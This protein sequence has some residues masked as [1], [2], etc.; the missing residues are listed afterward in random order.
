MPSPYP[1]VASRLR[2]D[3]LL[4]IF[5]LALLSLRLVVPFVSG[6]FVSLVGED[7]TAGSKVF[8]TVAVLLVQS[9]VMLFIALF[10]ARGQ[11]GLSWQDLG[12]VPCKHEWIPRAIVFAFLMI[13]AV[14]LIN[15][16]VQEIMGG[17]QEN[18]QLQVL[19]PAGF[20]WGSYIS[21]MVISALVVPII[22][23]IVFRGLLFGWLAG[24]FGV[25]IGAGVSALIFSIL[26]G[27]PH[28]IPSLCVLGVALAY[29]YEKSG[30]LWPPII[31]HGAFNAVMTTLLY[32]ALA[33]G[34]EL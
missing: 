7:A 34:V 33:Q 26:H 19:A 32:Y 5:I 29:L 2:V 16:L 30:S 28:L 10:I 8:T 6:L 27:V 22:E 24:R 23:E 15:I 4:L 9:L 17:E 20:S 31:L 1:F 18:P 11:R 3:D 21:I 14:S 25:A 13:P 12:L